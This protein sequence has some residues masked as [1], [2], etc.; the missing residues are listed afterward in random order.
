M[1]EQF[2]TRVADAVAETFKLAVGTTAVRLGDPCKAGPCSQSWLS[3][4]NLGEGAL[5][6]SMSFSSQLATE[7]AA[8]MFA[9][10]TTDV[11]FADIEDAIG[12]LC[13]IVSGCVKRLVLPGGAMGLPE[14]VRGREDPEDLETQ[15]LCELPFAVDGERLY[16]T[17]DGDRYAE[18]AA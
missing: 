7:V 3:S 8:S 1:D 12:E 9:L 4:V 14:V 10:P 15:L 18:V 2:R 17:I 16:V 11:V 13:S 5:R 6:I